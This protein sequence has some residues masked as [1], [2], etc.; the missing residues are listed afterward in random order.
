[1]APDRAAFYEYHASLMERGMVRRQSPSPMAADR[2]DDRPQRASAGA[3]AVTDDDFVVLA[4]EAGA[5]QLDDRRIRAKGRLEQARCS[6]STP[7]RG[8]Y[9]TMMT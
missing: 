2:R 1:M 5:L 6:S 9:V 3:R 4:S 8:G 7:L